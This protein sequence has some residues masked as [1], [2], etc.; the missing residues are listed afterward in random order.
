M[1]RI[2][3]NQASSYNNRN[4]LVSLSKLSQ[5]NENANFVIKHD[6]LSKTKPAASQLKWLATDYLC[7]NDMKLIKYASVEKENGYKL[8]TYFIN[9]CKDGTFYLHTIAYNLL[10]GVR[11]IAQSYNTLD[12][13]M[14]AVNEHYVEYLASVK[15]FHI[16]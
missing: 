7:A 5:L 15:S 6:L 13:A 11:R 1:E 4:I 10:K 9:I 2:M 8:Y 14:A 3:K 12:K 16:E